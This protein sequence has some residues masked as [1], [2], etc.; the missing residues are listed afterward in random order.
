MN[1]LL[2]DSYN[3]IHRARFEFGGKLASGENQIIYIFFRS[4]KPILDRFSPDKV[5]FVLDGNPKNRLSIDSEY[6]GNRIKD[7]LSEEEQK[8]WESFHIQKRFIINFVK[9][10][11]PFTTVYHP[12]FECDDIIN[13]LALNTDGN[14]TIV[15]SDTDFIQTLDL[16]E[17]TKL[18]NPVAQAYRERMDV[19]YLRYKSL[20]GDRTDNIPGVKGVGKV[21]AIKMLKDN[22]IFNKKIM[23]EEFRNQYN[24]SY[25]LVKFA[26]L[27]YYKN[28]IEYYIGSFDKEFL[29]NSF[30][31]LNFKSMLSEPYF[32][33]YSHT[34]ESI[35]ESN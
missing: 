16:S 31:E 29:R 17:S 14:K 20:V 21:G 30:T 12:D 27:S 4:L 26:D 2:L 15:S 19:E 7:N 33:K 9:N 18:W 32:S 10:N 35:G 11:L 24:H 34:M 13:Y 25:S 1:I 23:D 3:L 8:Y 28:N 22:S 5:Y 6:K